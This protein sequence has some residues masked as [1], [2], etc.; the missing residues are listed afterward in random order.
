MPNGD[1]EWARRYPLSHEREPGYVTTELHTLENRVRQLL[2]LIPSTPQ[3]TI[4]ATPNF[5]LVKAQ[6]GSTLKILDAFRAEGY[7]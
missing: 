5:W 4:E 6:I 2:E 1:G 3:P 7:K